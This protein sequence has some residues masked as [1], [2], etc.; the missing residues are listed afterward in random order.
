MDLLI[1]KP[2]SIKSL[3]DELEE[4][5]KG[6]WI[7]KD[8]GKEVSY[9]KDHHS[10]LMDEH[11]SSF[12]Y[13]HRAICIGN[14]LSKLSLEYLMDVGGSNGF[15]TKYL[16]KYVSTVLLEPHHEAIRNAR[17]IGLNTIIQS[18]FQSANF[19]ESTIPAIGLF[20]VLEHIEEDEA[21]LESLHYTLKTD[22]VLMIT[23]PSYQFLWSYFDQQVGHYRR[24]NRRNLIRKLENTGFKVH[25][26]SYLFY[27][28]PIPIWLK[29]GIGGA[30]KSRN[31]RSQ[32][33]KNNSIVG[34]IMNLLLLPEYLLLKLRISIPFGS[35]CI[36]V[37]R[38]V[39][40]GL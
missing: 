32:H 5:E 8:K 40:T 11:S 3:S 37:A 33:F 24:Y 1:E 19:K 28:L 27:V 14:L 18:S 17:S 39:K 23:V 34:R 10:V 38:K 35:S 6:Y 21:F 2:I 30:P 7:V 12:W 16:S 25:F 15:L 22:G 31:P 9:P 29:R 26:F 20:D 4:V 13:Q 36:C